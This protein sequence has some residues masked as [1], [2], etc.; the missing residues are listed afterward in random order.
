MDK[1]NEQEVVTDELS[2]SICSRCNKNKIIYCRQMC[3]ACYNLIHHNRDRHLANLKR[4]RE[5]NR[6]Y[7]KDYYLDNKDKYHQ[8]KKIT[9]EKEEVEESRASE[10]LNK[11]ILRRLK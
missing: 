8:K 9:E 3:K 10:Q 2:N 7:F 4:W 11:I 1:E 5:K 6:Q